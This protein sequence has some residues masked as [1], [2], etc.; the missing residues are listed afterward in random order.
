MMMVVIVI[1]MMYDHLQRRTEVQFFS[2]ATK[3]R[4][5]SVQL[6]VV[7]GGGLVLTN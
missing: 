5:R 7:R 3:N 4:P 1:M 6:D 2:E